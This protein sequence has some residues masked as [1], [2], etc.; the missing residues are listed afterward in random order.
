MIFFV[1][2]GLRGGSTDSSDSSSTSITGVSSFTFRLDPLVLGFVTSTT[3]LPLGSSVSTTEDV[4]LDL[5]AV[6]RAGAR[7]GVFAALAVRERVLFPRSYSWSSESDAGSAAL[8]ERVRVVFCVCKDAL[9]VV[10]RIPFFFSGSSVI[11]AV[12]KGHSV[13]R[14]AILRRCS[15]LVTSGLAQ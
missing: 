2:V 3:S 12:K 6:F 7:T 11:L 1:R 4:T 5:V 14:F 8:V 15:S 9:D 13:P 10:L